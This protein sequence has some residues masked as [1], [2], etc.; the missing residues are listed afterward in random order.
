MQCCS[1]SQ[2]S[3]GDL[4]ENVEAPR[5]AADALHMFAADIVARLGWHRLERLLDAIPE[6]NDDFIMF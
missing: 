2:L 1:L 3:R 6:S 4:P 5:H